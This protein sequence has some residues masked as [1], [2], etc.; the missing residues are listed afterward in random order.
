MTSI[1]L[2]N[3]HSWQT[4]RIDMQQPMGAYDSS[5][6][7]GG[8]LASTNSGAE[9]LQWPNYWPNQYYSSQSRDVSGSRVMGDAGGNGFLGYSQFPP[10]YSLTSSAAGTG[11][12]SISSSSIEMQASSCQFY[13][14]PDEP[15]H[16]ACSRPIQVHHLGTSDGCPSPVADRGYFKTAADSCG[17]YSALLYNSGQT[18]QSG[19]CICLFNAFCL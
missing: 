3:Q 5:H 8:A 18:S 17:Q 15:V 11:R 9:R 13:R 14:A 16:S 7:W 10:M 12:D 1:Y 4:S 6:W 19:S 2:P